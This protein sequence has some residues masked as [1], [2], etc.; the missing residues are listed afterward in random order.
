MAMFLNF[1]ICVFIK[2]SANPSVPRMFH[3]DYTLACRFS[4]DFLGGQNYNKIWRMNRYGLKREK[5]LRK[6][7]DYG[8]SFVAGLFFKI[9]RR[10]RSYLY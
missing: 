7:R 9:R 4:D 2:I 1:R 5:F 8:V 3:S 10:A 6:R